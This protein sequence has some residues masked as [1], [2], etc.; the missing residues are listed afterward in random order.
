MQTERVLA[1]L[2]RQHPSQAVSSGQG[3]AR[4]QGLL[5]TSAIPT[6]GQSLR[7]QLLVPH[8]AIPSSGVRVR[9]GESWRL[10]PPGFWEAGS[11][12]RASSDR[13]GLLGILDLILLAALRS[14]GCLPPV[15][16]SVIKA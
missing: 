9:W 11:R 10:K 14:A 6:T 3:K 8:P 5:M 13:R 15:S 12:V 4:Q 2:G 1:V 7:V 16:Q